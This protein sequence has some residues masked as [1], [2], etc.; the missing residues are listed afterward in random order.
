[1]DVPTTIN[2]AVGPSFFTRDF[3]IFFVEL[4]SFFLGNFD[5]HVAFGLG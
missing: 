3:V 4:I 1:M 2:R 5:V